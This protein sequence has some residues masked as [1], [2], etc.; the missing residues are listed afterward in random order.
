MRSV[1]IAPLVLSLSTAGCLQKLGFD[2][3]GDPSPGDHDPFGDA[4]AGADHDPGIDFDLVGDLDPLLP[5][6]AY[7]RINDGAP[8]TRDAAVTLSLACWNCSEMALA[9]DDGCL[10]L[11][12]WRPVARSLEWTLATTN[13]PASVS[14]RFRNPN[15]ESACLTAGVIHDDTPPTPIDT[16]IDGD[17]HPSLTDSPPIY[18]QGGALDNG[19]LLYGYQ[20]ALGT[21]PGAGDVVPPT[22]VGRVALVELTGLS[23][24]QHTRYYASVRAVDNAGNVSAWRNGDGFIADTLPPAFSIDA[25]SDGE[26]LSTATV[27]IT[28]GCEVD[29][30]LEVTYDPGLTGQTLLSCP[31]GAFATEALVAGGN[32]DR[33]FSIVATDAAGNETT[34]SRTFSWGVPLPAG[35]S[36][37]D[38]FAGVFA[39][40]GFAD[41]ASGVDVRFN[42]PSGLAFD[43][44]HLYV[45]EEYNHTV[46]RID[47]ASGATTLIAG[48]PGEEDCRDGIGSAARFARPHGVAFT[49]GYLWVTSGCQA[50]HRIELGTGQTTIVAGS[51][52]GQTGNTDGT[53][54]SARFNTPTRVIVDQS[55]SAL[56]VIDNLGHRLRRVDLS[57]FAVTTVAGSPT[58]ASGYVNATGTAAQFN[59]PNDIVRAGND[60]FVTDTLNHA[61][62]RVTLTDEVTTFAGKD[63]PAA[64]GDVDAVG[65]AARFSYPF[66]IASDGTRL[67]VFEAAWGNNGVRE[68]ELGSAQVTRILGGGWSGAAVDGSFGTATTG[69]VLGA[70][71]A[72]GFLFFT[73]A[74]SHT[75]RKI[76]LTLRSV[77]TVAGHASPL[78]GD[79]GLR[80]RAGRSAQ[81][82]DPQQLLQLGSEVFFADRGNSAIRGVNLNDAQVTTL[83]G[84]NG[85][86]YRDGG[87]AVAQFGCVLG[88]ASD[89]ARLFVADSCNCVIRQVDLATE[90]TTTIAGTQGVCAYVNATGAAARFDQPN[91]LAWADG[92]LF[93]ADYV[94]CAVRAIDTADFSVTTFAGKAPPAV[95]SFANGTGTAARFDQVLGLALDGAA[96]YVSEPWVP[97]IRRIALTDAAVTTLAGDG[98]R[99]FA[100]GTGAAA[101]FN[102]AHGLTTDGTT[103]WVA[104]RNNHAVRSIVL[105]TGVVNTLVGDPTAGLERDGPFASARLLY[106]TAVLVT[107]Q[108]L[109]VTS[110]GQNLRIVH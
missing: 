12:A 54:L 25:P 51:T 53:G 69:N 82:R 106:P 26:P 77:S 20:Y 47:P 61:V 78:A 87:P 59:Q 84:G 14:V 63:P 66:S 3:P 110:G 100:D 17:F 18:W 107:G 10:S 67:W 72:G 48:S 44:T 83:T 50:I 32:G 35:M 34:H 39:R 92:R 68:I 79:A 22:L 30:L 89:G 4:T 96:L 58:A 65:T 7:L 62:R 93:V 2:G 76:D 75:L 21:T 108:G 81:L 104:D 28:G 55:D 85:H 52:G 98:T 109:L 70:L 91:H 38:L 71:F 88:L 46:R 16:V 64:S 6:A 13:G 41:A 101:R 42:H 24:T 74:G 37:V 40:S 60:V 8:F 73:D 29:S 9:D 86:G 19:S 56:L 1:V 36:R 103:L 23:L 97:R 33:S 11:G 102:G 90:L 43:G 15:G 45:A 105:A 31:T 94:N 5:W 49:S 95:C 27:S 99:G 80:D 57:T